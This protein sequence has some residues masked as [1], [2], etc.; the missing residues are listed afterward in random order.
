MWYIVRYTPG[1]VEDFLHVV[2]ELMAFL[3]CIFAQLHHLDVDYLILL[4]CNRSCALFLFRHLRLSHEHLQNSL[5][6]HDYSRHHAVASLPF[7]AKVSTSNYLAS[8]FV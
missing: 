2:C 7:L 5:Y 6:P 8:S 3:H 1:S 4:Y